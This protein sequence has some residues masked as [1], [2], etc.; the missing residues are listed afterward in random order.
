MRRIGKERYR[1]RWEDRDGEIQRHMRRIG[2]ER[3]RDR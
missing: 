1:S 3:Y 2:K